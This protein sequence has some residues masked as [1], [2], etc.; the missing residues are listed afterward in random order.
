MK[1]IEL[2]ILS[3]FLDNGYVIEE[4]KTNY[5]SGKDE[6]KVARENG[7]KVIWSTTYIEGQLE[8]IISLYVFENPATI[9]RK[10]EFFLHEILQTSFFAYSAKKNLVMKIIELERLLE[11]EAKDDLSKA[12]RK[13]M[14]YRNSFAHGSLHYEFGSGCFLS[15]FSSRP[16]KE[17]LDDSYW[18]TLEGYY[19][20]A[21]SVLEKMFRSLRRKFK[22]K[23][24]QSSE[25]T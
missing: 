2:P 15:F 12:L 21:S 23:S 19:S 17:A 16:R 20:N 13:V 1:K 9:T 11:G 3:S 4:V 5:L 7:G 25:P 8:K 14:D 22:N 6:L 18:E 24:N 10:T